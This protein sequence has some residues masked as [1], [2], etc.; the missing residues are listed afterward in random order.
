MQMHDKL[1]SNIN[2]NS[3]TLKEVD[4]IDDNTLKVTYMLNTVKMSNKLEYNLSSN[5]RLD[6][7]SIVEMLGGQP[8][9][10]TE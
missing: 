10:L 4:M 7:N 9:F 6:Y 1:N 2:L 3:M 5:A 8:T